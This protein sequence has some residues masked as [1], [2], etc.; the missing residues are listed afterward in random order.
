[1]LA[2]NHS[3]ND[4]RMALSML[5]SK[6]RLMRYSDSTRKTYYHMFRAFLKFTYPKKLHQITQTDIYS[7][8]HH[9][10]IDKK[11]STAYQNQSINSIKFY[12]EHVLGQDKQLY[13]LERPKKKE[14]LPHILSMEDVQRILNHT[15]SLKHRAM[16]TTIYSAG[17]RIGELLNLKIADIDSQHMRIWVREGKGCKDRIT[18]LSPILLDLL[19]DYYTYHQPSDY[20][21]EGP[22]G[23][24]YSASSVR[25]VLH[26]AVAKAGIRQTVVPHTLRHSFATHLLE[27]GTNLRYIQ[28]LL[29]HTSSK[30]TEIYTH[31]SSKKLDEVKSP[32]D[33]LPKSPIFER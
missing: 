12:L 30:T 7:Y 19:R 33:Y 1:M 28:T 31:V 9:I 18:V 32:L 3:Q 20:L 5:D 26:R 4:Y 27:H 10:V 24:K 15:K 25:K 23:K 22:E 16:L 13:A 11:C 21:F 29:G 14:K 2:L 8:Q 6:I 17:L